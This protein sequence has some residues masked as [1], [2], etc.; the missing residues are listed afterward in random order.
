MRLYSP[1]SVK[2]LFVL[3][4]LALLMSVSSAAV[5]KEFTALEQLVQSGKLDEATDLIGTLKPYNDEERAFV[6]F[7]AARLKVKYAELKSGYELVVSKYPQS[8]YAQA[9]RMELA[10]LQI[11]DRDWDAAAEN[12]KKVTSNYLLERFYWQGLIYW[13]Q[14]DFDKAISS[15][16]N[17]LRLAPKGTYCED[18]YYLMAECY[19]A[20]KKSYS[21]I[22]ALNKLHDLGLPD[23]DQQYLSYKLGYAHEQSGKVVEAV[24]FYKQGYFLDKY[25]QIA[26][27]IE[28]RLFELR[29]T[30]KNIDIG[31]LYPYSMLQIPPA[32][33]SAVDSP[34]I[35]APP[36]SATT[37]ASPPPDLEAP[38]KLKAKPSS[39]FYV[40]AGRFS[41]E[42]N[43]NKLVLNIRLLSLPAVYY[44]DVS[45][46][47][48]TWVVLSGAYENRTKAEE[49]KNLLLSQD[50]NC[51]VAQY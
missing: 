26:Y 23:I 35:P 25:S 11:L 43:A 42:A 6:G 12:L 1:L 40:Q 47:K 20:Q 3:L 38:I 16:E 7:Y 13:W 34:V 39:G 30:S 24:N 29:Y 4:G 10:K 46:G 48:K 8:D 17:Y 37:A 18:A 14:D 36:K 28:D 22:T 41:Q 19:L 45:G 33:S 49:A 31:F 15:V 51:F 2:K 44:E 21:A 32:E 50:I 5:R 27:T 9:A